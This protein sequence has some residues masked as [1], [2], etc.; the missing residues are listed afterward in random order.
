MY[1]L[2]LVALTG[3]AVAMLLLALGAAGVAS[4]DPRANYCD[5]ED[6]WGG[7]FSG[8]L[9]G[10]QGV[11]V[12]DIFNQAPPR[13][14]DDDG[15]EDFALASA[16]AGLGNAFETV[17]VTNGAMA[18]GHGFLFVLPG[19]AAFVIAGHGDHPLIGQFKLS[20]EGE[21]LCVAEEGQA[22]DAMFHFRSNSGLMDEGF[23]GLA[24]CEDV[25]SCEGEGD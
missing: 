25:E 11:V 20:A 22:A 8:A 21:V 16:M 13:M 6:L 2:R 7:P 24:R 1:K 14:T 9:P 18:K 10:N 5:V 4:A 19:S 17:L 3:A 23:V 12:F 15:S